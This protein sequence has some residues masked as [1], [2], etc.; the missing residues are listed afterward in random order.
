MSR[1][2]TSQDQCCYGLWETVRDRLLVRITRAYERLC[3]WQGFL[4]EREPLFTYKSTT[5]IDDAEAGLKMVAYA[6][7]VVRVWTAFLFAVY[8]EYR[9]WYIPTD[10]IT[11]A[12]GLG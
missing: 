9:L 11:F 6:E 10:S 4:F 8:S 7:R 12:C 3:V 1:F 2:V 5:V